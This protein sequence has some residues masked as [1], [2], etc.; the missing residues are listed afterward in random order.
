[1]LHYLT[2]SDRVIVLERCIGLL[3]PGGSI[4][5]R[6]AD[7]SK[8]KRH[9]GSKLTEVFSTKIFRFNKTQNNLEFFSSQEII[10]LAKEHGLSARV[11]DNTKFTSNIMIVL[12]KE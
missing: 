6:D 3:N 4:I 10:S 11:I 2:A 8:T 5:V 7:Q 1:V 9:K 12:N